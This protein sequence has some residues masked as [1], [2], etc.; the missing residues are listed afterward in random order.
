M[1]L[2]DGY[3][4]CCDQRTQFSSKD[5]WFRDNYK[6]ENCN[7]IPRERALMFCIEKFYPT[8]RDL[9]IH[10]SSPAM[11]GASARL[12]R[13]A[14]NYFSSHFFQGIPSGMMHEGCRCE[15]LENLSFEDESIDLHISQDVLEHLFHPAQAFKEIART[16]MPG[17][18]HIFTT[19]LVKKNKST[20]WCATQDEDGFTKYLINPPEYHGNPLT[21]EG[22]LVTVHWGYDITQFV[23]NACGLY[24]DLIYVDS[25]ELGIRAEYIEVL[26]TRKPS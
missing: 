5:D 12:Q 26:I 13:D 4:N 17:G 9:V 10:E 19:P 15:D 2:N 6:C 8:W 24:T 21:E 16:L 1:L 25:L 22:S 18:A 20:S 7:S 14:R 23:F 11:R 3:C